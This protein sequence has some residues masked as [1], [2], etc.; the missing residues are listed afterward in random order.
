MKTLTL[1]QSPSLPAMRQL[2]LC[3]CHPTRCL[4]GKRFS[5]NLSDSE[6]EIDKSAK[7]LK[8]SEDAKPPNFR[9]DDINIAPFIM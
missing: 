2:G 9:V 6:M 3:S 1:T 4:G 5:R 7:V 8:K